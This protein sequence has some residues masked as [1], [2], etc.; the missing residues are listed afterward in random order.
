MTL[1]RWTLLSILTA[2]PACGGRYDVGDP[3]P[4][5]GSGGTGAAGKTGGSGSSSVGATDGTSGGSTATGGT[6]DASGGTTAKPAGGAGGTVGGSGG[7]TPG[8]SG[9]STSTGGGPAGSGGATGN[10]V[11]GLGASAAN[12]TYGT[13]AP[14]ATVWARIVDLVNDQYPDSLPPFDG[15]YLSPAMAA[16]IVS[17]ELSNPRSGG[18]GG[19]TRFV[20]G[21]LAVGNDAD[22]TATAETQAGIMGAQG[23][24]FA[25][26]IAPD[27][28]PT[29]F[30]DPALNRLRPTLSERGNWLLLS[31][32]CADIGPPLPGIPP[33]ATVAGL[34][35]RQALAA[36]D[37][38]ASCRGCH[39]I[40]DPLGG[41]LEGIDP[42]TGLPRTTDNGLPIDTSGSF[43]SPVGPSNF[44]FSGIEDLAP[45]FAT[46]CEVARCFVSSVGKD[47]TVTLGLGAL[48]DA[49]ID[50]ILY[51]YAQQGF[52]IEALLRA[53]VQTPTF[54]E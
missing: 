49:E 33:L 11:C 16:T 14:A 4:A 3:V 13:P 15:E 45:Q 29:L 52:S 21:W 28:G 9:G 23:V 48:S 17:D 34:T 42:E 30:E 10:T 41:S 51:E 27:G 22:A 53:L 1:P 20:K 38:G 25:T 8:G 37:A 43:Q 12:L 18:T 47:A 19:L 50:F 2:F 7:T 26:L 54:L 39:S 35:R 5:D 40:L 6:S 31:Q 32:L 24:T 44:T 46:S 36:A